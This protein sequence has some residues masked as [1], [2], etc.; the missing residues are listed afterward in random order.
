MAVLRP[1]AVTLPP[2]PDLYDARDQREFRRIVMAALAAPVQDLVRPSLSVQVTPAATMYTIIVTYTGTMTYKIDGGADNDGTGSPQTL[3]I[4]RPTLAEKEIVYVFKAV[5]DS[6]TVTNTVTIAPQTPEDAAVT[7][8]ID[9]CISSN[10]GAAPP[11]YN[12]LDIPFTY[13]GMPTGTV[14]DVSY[15]NAVSGGMDSD[16]GIAMTTSPQT[17]TFTSVT[18]AS[19]P[20]RGAVTVVAKKNGQVLA[21]AVRNKVYVT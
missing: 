8:I 12:R 18:F 2:A 20:G 10:N 7:L 4:T 19:T 16:I 13:S 9:A 15:N 17:K 11:P 6:Q 3:T 5:A 14:F 21:T 1:P